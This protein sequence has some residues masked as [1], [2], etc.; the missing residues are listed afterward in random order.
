MRKYGNL[1]KNGCVWAAQWPTSSE[2][3]IKF[4]PS[5]DRSWCEFFKIVKDHGPKNPPP[6]CNLGGLF[7]SPSWI[8]F[9]KKSAECSVHLYSSPCLINKS[10]LL[11]HWSCHH[12]FDQM[13]FPSL[14][15][16]LLQD[17]R[18][19]WKINNIFDQSLKMPSVQLFKPANLEW[20]FCRNLNLFWKAV[21]RWRWR[22]F[23]MSANRF[24]L[25][26]LH[27]FGGE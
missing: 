6:G 4:D 20:T 24:H 14:C 12:C 3:K 2:L 19:Y 16:L 1:S 21:H 17:H 8:F 15:L 9:Q 13:L 18:H 26:S 22:R 23:I 5:L 10:L 7:P 25:N 11:P 27:E